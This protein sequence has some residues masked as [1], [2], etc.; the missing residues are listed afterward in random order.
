MTSLLAAAR[1]LPRWQRAT[2]ILWLILIG[3]I[4]GLVLLWIFNRYNMRDFS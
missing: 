3:P 2:M 4:S 1:A